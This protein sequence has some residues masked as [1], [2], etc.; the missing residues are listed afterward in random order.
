MKT[1]TLNDYIITEQGEIINKRNGRKVKP[2]PNGKGYLRVSISGKLQFVHR[3][4]AEKHI[5]NP[6]NKPQVN[7]KDGNKLN[8]SV[9]NLEWATNQENRDHAVKNR[10]HLCGGDCAWAKLDWEKV[11]FI[12]SHNEYTAKQLAEMYNVMVSTIRA[13]RQG[14]SWKK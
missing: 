9:D 3:L 14:K 6:E 4:V 13:V 12:R 10:L 1:L 5:P 11:D 2:Q 8:N 7:H